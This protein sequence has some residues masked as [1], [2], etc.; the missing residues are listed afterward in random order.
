MDY[1]RASRV[2][3]SLIKKGILGRFKTGNLMNNKL[4][5]SYIAIEKQKEA[6]Q[7]K[8][9][10]LDKQNTKLQLQQEL[11]QAVYNL[12]VATTQKTEAVIRNGQKVYEANADKIRNA[13]KSVQDAT[14][15]ITK[16]NLQEQLDA[17]NDQLDDY[18]DKVEE[19]IDALDKIKEKWSEIAENVQK[20]QELWM[21]RPAKGKRKLLHILPR[22]LNN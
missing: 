9:D 22:K 13:Q 6:I 10:L 15:N 12:H 16:N 18:N 19:Q 5:E 3:N 14:F 21:S 20:A 7:D 17:L 8:I 1:S 11:E 4:S 2:V